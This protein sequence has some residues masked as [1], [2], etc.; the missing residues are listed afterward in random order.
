MKK[1][2]VTREGNYYTFRC[3]HCNLY[4]FVFDNEI[5]CQIFRHACMKNTHQQV[6]PH[7]SKEECD[8][9]SKEGLVYGCSKPFKLI[10]DQTGKIIQVVACN[11][12]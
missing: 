2:T 6:S 7:A 12:I 10:K 5:N 3:P 9:L 11:Y 8:R 4:I 1:D